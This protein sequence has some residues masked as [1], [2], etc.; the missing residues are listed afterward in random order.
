MRS[1]LWLVFLWVG[2]HAAPAA[3]TPPNSPPVPAPLPSTP[4]EPPARGPGARVTVKGKAG[5][6]VFDVE[7]ALDGPSQERGLMFRKEVP[8]GTGMLFLFPSEDQHV[9]WMKNTLVPLDMLFLS[10]G[11]RIVGIVENAEPQTLTPRDPHAAS[12]YVLEVAGGTA[13]ARGMRVGDAVEF[14]NVP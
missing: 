3:S 4:K 11:R 8:A 1:G 2:C 9:F 13:F 7:L 14:E 12:Q 6:T 10:K 5:P